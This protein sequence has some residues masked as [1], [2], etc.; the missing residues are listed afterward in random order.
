[1]SEFDEFN[2]LLNEEFKNEIAKT[3][4]GLSTFDQFPAKNYKVTFESIELVRTKS[5]RPAVKVVMRIISEDEY[6][7]KRIYHYLNLMGK[8]GKINGF[9]VKSCNAFLNNLGSDV[10]VKLE[11][12]DEFERLIN[13]VFLSTKQYAYYTINLNYTPDKYDSSKQYAN[14]DVIEAVSYLEET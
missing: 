1:M 7:E 12:F 3:E 5:N 9:L 10:T 6:N 2:A 4:K 13:A 8:N 14:V 11:S